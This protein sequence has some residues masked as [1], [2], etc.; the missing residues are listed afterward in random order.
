[1]IT[2]AVKKQE[3]FEEKKV[4]NFSNWEITPEMEERLEKL[5]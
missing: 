4:S 1:V 2:E 3:E 5:D